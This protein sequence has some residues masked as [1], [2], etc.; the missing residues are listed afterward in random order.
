MER[1]GPGLRWLGSWLPRTPGWRAAGRDRAA[2]PTFPGLRGPRGLVALWSPGGAPAPDPPAW[3]WRR[4]A[5]AEPSGLPRGPA[6]VDCPGGDEGAAGGWPGGR[7]ALRRRGA[8][9]APYWDGTALRFP[10]YGLTHPLAAAQAG[11]IAPRRWLPGLCCRAAPCPRPPAS[12]W[13]SVRGAGCAGARTR[14]E[15]SSGGACVQIWARHVLA[16]T[17]LHGWR[18]PVYRPAG[19]HVRPSAAGQG[20]GTPGSRRGRC[21]GSPKARSAEGPRHRSYGPSR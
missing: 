19:V 20:M 9:D 2:A 15:R 3:G 10:R 17:G 7:L 8:L 16:G 21:G 12:L 14:G 1:A 18:R 13:V 6:H 4:R 5:Q 11:G